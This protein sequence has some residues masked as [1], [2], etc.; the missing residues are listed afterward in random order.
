MLLLLK[1]YLL[2]LALSASKPIK[3]ISKNE[4]LLLISFDGFR[5]D[6]LQMYNLTNFTYLRDLGSHADYI[7]NSFSTV[8][9]PNHWT[10]VTGLYEVLLIS[11]S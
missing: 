10:I 7:Y 1:L 2:L 9:F 4:M 8:T 6:Y 11:L 5:W 3:C